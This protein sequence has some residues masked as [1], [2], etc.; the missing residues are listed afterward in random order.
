MLK[1]HK[2]QKASL[3]IITE[4]EMLFRLNQLNKMKSIPPDYYR[5]RDATSD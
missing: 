2:K 1:L 4:D 5:E 3:S